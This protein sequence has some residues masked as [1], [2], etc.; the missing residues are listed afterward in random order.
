MGYNKGYD[1]FTAPH[2][3]AFRTSCRK[4]NLEGT[5]L[6]CIRKV[7]PFILNVIPKAALFISRMLTAC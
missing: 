6:L 5:Y 7:S 2:T 1:T 4:G 3:G